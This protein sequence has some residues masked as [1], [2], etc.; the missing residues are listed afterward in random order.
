MTFVASCKLHENLNFI[1]MKYICIFFSRDVF[2]KSRSNK[3]CNQAI[4]F[5]DIDSR[6]KGMGWVNCVFISALCGYFFAAQEFVNSMNKFAIQSW[7]AKDRVRNLLTSSHNSLIWQKDVLQIYWQGTTCK[8]LFR[9]IEVPCNWNSVS[10]V[11]QN[12]DTWKNYWRVRL[13][14]L[15]YTFIAPK[16]KWSCR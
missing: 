15:N 13:P 4:F 9:G 12:S 8:P 5:E 1:V 7:K 11:E 10:Q 2:A 16:T 6:H 14:V 3:T